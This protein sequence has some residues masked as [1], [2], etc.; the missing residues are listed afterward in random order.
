MNQ[1]RQPRALIGAL[2]IVLGTVFI[3]MNLG[4]IEHVPIF[5]FWPLILIMIGLSKLIQA[6]YGK[7]RWDGAWLLLLGVWFQMVT[8]RLLG[9]TYRNSWPLLLIIWGVYLT[10]AALARRSPM[11]FAEENR[12]GN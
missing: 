7:A 3:L 11:T 12:N 6:D 5:R 8:L 4:L 9:L 10:G 2:L 1:F